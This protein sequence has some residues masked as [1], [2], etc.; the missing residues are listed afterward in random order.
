MARVRQWIHALAR[1]KRSC[2][3]TFQLDGISLLRQ[4]QFEEFLY[5]KVAPVAE[6]CVFFLVNNHNRTGAKSVVMGLAGKAQHFVKNVEETKARGISII[7]R[8]TG[9]GTV[10]VDEC[11][12]NTSII[13][14]TQ[15]ARNVSPTGICDWSYENIFR[16][17]GIFND[18]F[19]VVEG[20]FVVK[21]LGPS[22]GESGT[23][24]ANAAE[25]Y[26]KVAGNSQAFNTKAFVHH[27]VFLW[28]M[29]P[30]ISQVLLHPQKT[31]DYRNGRDHMSFLRSVREALHPSHHAWTMDDFENALCERAGL[32]QHQLDCRVHVNV[33]ARCSDAGDIRD[34]L[35]NDATNLSDEFI[36]EAISMLEVPSTISL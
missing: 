6:R 23:T 20:D 4:L 15:F 27:S 7:K 29:S 24:T 12:L 14:S 21:G 10:I 19:G 30:L 17:C 26:H 36:G 34:T 16:N 9:G 3:Y 31:P 25:L 5:R 28:S 8:F 11:S 1:Q 18:R 32:E 33:S 22:S 13:A 2:F 35:Q